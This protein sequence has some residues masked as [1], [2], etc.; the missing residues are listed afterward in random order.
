[1]SEIPRKV[2]DIATCFQFLNNFWQINIAIFCVVILVL[3]SAMFH[4]PGWMT[5]LTGW[6][7]SPPVADIIT[8]PERSAMLQVNHYPPN[9]QSPKPPLPQRTFIQGGACYWVFTSDHTILGSLNLNIFKWKLC[10]MTCEYV[11][12]I[13]AFFVS[14]YVDS[15]SFTHSQFQTCLKFVTKGDDSIFFLWIVLYLFF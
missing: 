6:S 1:M 8:R 5:T 3:R 2:A 12:T 9:Q 15:L 7:R 4:L 11:I 14:N 13:K 10:D